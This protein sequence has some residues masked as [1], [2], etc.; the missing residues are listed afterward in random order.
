MS[1]AERPVRVGLVGYGSAGRG[2]HAPLLREAGL[3]VALV[4]TASPDRAAAAAQEVPGARVVPD[5]DA[6][7]AAGDGPDGVDLVVLASPTGV[8]E[9]QVLACVAAGRPVLVDKPLA[10]DA[11]GAARCVR[12]ARAAG[13]PLTVFQ[14]RRWDDEQRA[15]AA[16]LA[17]GELGDVLRLERR[18]ER[19]RPVPKD[20]WRENA[21][22]SEGGGILLDLQSH[23]VDSA[24]QLLGPVES[25]YAE[26]SAVTTAAEDTTFL[27]LRHADGARSHLSA[28]SAAG[29]PGPRT[30]VLGTRGS[31][32]VVPFEGEVSG[33]AGVLDDAPGSTGWVVRGEE[34]TPV[35]TPPGGHADLYRA[36]AA[37]VR[38][39]GPWPVDP[40]DAVAVLAVLDAA[41]ASAA[42]GRVVPVEVPDLA[43]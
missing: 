12:A 40:A 19:W 9:E 37:A 2:I 38:G 5:L 20:R 28:V 26:V 32:V 42:Q 29:A 1:A 11:E 18:W 8:H 17:A 16:V 30:R 23:L 39:D 35:P 15:L 36:A 33:F 14:N 10:V 22:A 41:R 4:A 13:V 6:V 43:P 24:V 3:D 21:P 7:L 31:Y 25:V 34:R 27:A